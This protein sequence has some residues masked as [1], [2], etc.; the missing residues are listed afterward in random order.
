M[1]NLFS[2][3]YYANV[4]E[5]RIKVQRMIRKGKWDHNC[6]L[7]E[8]KKELLEVLNIQNDHDVLQKLEQMQKKIDELVNK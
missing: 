1:Y 3:H 7:S 2:R 6:E 8:M 4:H 5:V